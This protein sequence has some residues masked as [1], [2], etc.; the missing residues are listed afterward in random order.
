MDWTEAPAFR[1]KPPANG[2]SPILTPPR[3]VSTLPD[4]QISPQISQPRQGQDGPATH[5]QDGHAATPC[6][7]AAMTRGRGGALLPST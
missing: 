3:H 5:G 1:R 4:F 6:G 2:Y 7:H